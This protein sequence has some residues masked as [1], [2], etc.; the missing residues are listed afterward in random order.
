VV[1]RCTV[2]LLD[3]LGKRDV[4]LVDDVP[5]DED[6][7]A[8]LLWIDRRKC[9]LLTHSGTLFPLFAADVRKGD[10]RFLGPLV[11]DLVQTA[12]GQEQFPLTRSA[13]SI[14]MR[15]ASPV[16]PAAGCSGS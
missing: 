16:R 12:L 8:N 7:Y 3:L 14:P 6:W 4:T 5:S 10:L 1:L 11:V 2:R 15:P 9:L 13:R